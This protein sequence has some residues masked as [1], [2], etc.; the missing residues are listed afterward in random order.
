MSG[1]D[2]KDEYLDA[3][4]NV[5]HWSN[6]RFAQLTVFM[7]ITS[8]LIAAVF[9]PGANSTSAI[10][11]FTKVAGILTVIIFWI[12][13]ERTMMFWRNFVKRATSLEKELGFQQYS[14][15]PKGS[16][17]TTGNAIRLLFFALLGFWI[18]A[19]FWLK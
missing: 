8:A 1:R 5:R 10:R 13:E 17:I 11:V 18:S 4:E 7:V 19:F 2:L 6:L 12:T 15:R 9:Q 14:T 16:I 3:S